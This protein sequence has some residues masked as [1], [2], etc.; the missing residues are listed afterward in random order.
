LAQPLSRTIEE[1]ALN[2]RPLKILIVDDDAD[3]RANISDILIDRGYL[4]D[5]APN[6]EVALA[7]IAANCSSRCDFDICLLDFK[8]P[9]MDGVELL[10]RIRTECPNVH[11]IMITAFAGDD[12]IQKAID[13]GTWKVMKKPVD[14]PR[15]LGL[16]DE[17]S[18]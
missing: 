5:T 6:G 8:M 7:K 15:L 13:A 18:V 10:E 17:V 16:I 3:I 12:G 11:A 9:G 14:I 1:F 4:I 2:P